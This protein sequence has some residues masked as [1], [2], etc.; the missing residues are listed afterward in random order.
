MNKEAVVKAVDR[1]WD[2]A[3]VERRI[4]AGE[5]DDAL[6]DWM[7]QDLDAILARLDTGIAEQRER[8]DTL[9]ERMKISGAA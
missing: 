4:S 3:E 5:V 2:P 1:G 9:L 7:M 6:R 8:L